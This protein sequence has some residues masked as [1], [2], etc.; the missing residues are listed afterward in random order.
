MGHAAMGYVQT[1]A[2]QCLSLVPIVGSPYNF[3]SAPELN[4]KLA[5]SSFVPGLLPLQRPCV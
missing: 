3:V 4:L 1:R 2:Q 5:L